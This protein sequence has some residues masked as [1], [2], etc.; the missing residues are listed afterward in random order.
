MLL[1]VC[2]QTK[3]HTLKKDI[4]NFCKVRYIPLW[5]AH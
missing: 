5:C 4:L 1:L 3:M 2:K